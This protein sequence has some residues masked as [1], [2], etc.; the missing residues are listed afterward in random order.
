MHL[1]IMTLH[2]R[3]L[4]VLGC[5]YVDDVLIDAPYSISQV[6]I[7]AAMYAYILNDFLLCLLVYVLF[8]HLNFFL[9]LSSLDTI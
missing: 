6:T 8:V 9:G 1:P 2:E 7:Y 5:K 3:V 4:S